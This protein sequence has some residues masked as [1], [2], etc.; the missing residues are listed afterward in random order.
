MISNNTF[1]T[2]QD[3]VFNNM[4]LTTTAST[5]D[6]SSPG[7]LEVVIQ[8]LCTPYCQGVGI[9]FCLIIGRY[10]IPPALKN[11]FNLFFNGGQQ[12]P[13]I[14][15][16]HVFL[17]GFN[18]NMLGNNNQPADE[19]RPPV[20]QPPV[21]QARVT[22]PRVTQPS[23]TQ[24]PVTQA[25]VT[26]ARVTQ[27]PVTQ[28]PVT[29]PPVTQPPVRP[30]KTAGPSKTVDAKD[31]VQDSDGGKKSIKSSSVGKNPFKKIKDGRR[32]T[33]VDRGECELDALSLPGDGKN[34]KSGEDTGNPSQ[35][36]TEDGQLGNVSKPKP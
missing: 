26:Q 22:Q 2:F 11:I 18:G 33:A 34:V 16:F 4:S 8:F 10:T 35:N 32:K 9:F 13:L 31:S 27:A 15:L 7:Q 3:V 30:S 29:Q 17:G 25:R 1:E 21:T 14:P 12:G 23:V 6:Q 36:P 19:Q 5:Q 20:T 28:P 24:A